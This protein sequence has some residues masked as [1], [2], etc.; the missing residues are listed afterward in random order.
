MFFANLS[1]L[2]FFGL[3]ALA[4]GATL[5]LYLLTRTRHR[6]VVS[7]LKFWH[8]AG[9]VP[10]QARRKRIDQPW[11]LLMQLLAIALLLLAMA[12]PRLG[13]P[14]ASGRDHVLLMDTSAWMGARTANGTL[15]GEAVRQALGWVRNLPAQDRVMVVRAAAL[16]TPATAFES[17]RGKVEAAIRA[18]RPGADA[19]DIEQAFSLATQAQRLDARQ[20]GEIAYAGASRVS[21][22]DPE[23]IAAPA[24]L[25]VLPVETPVENIGFTRLWLRR[26]E[27]R[28]DLWQ[29][30]VSARNYGRQARTAPMTLALGGAVIASRAMDLPAGGEATA[31]VEVRTRAAGWIEA[32]LDA[33]D[34]LESDN[35]ARLEIP[36]QPALRVAVYSP[37]PD[38]LRALLAS[39]KR[40]EP[41]FLGFSQY[42]PEPA[43]TD[44]IVL[45]RFAPPQPP[46]KPS[47]WIQPPADAS[48]IPA[49]AGQGTLELAHWNASHPLGAG[50]RARDFKLDQALLLTPGKG[51][52]AVAEAAGGA[53][54]AARTAAPRAVVLGFHPMLSPMRYEVTAPLLMANIYHW[55]APEVFMR[56]EVLTGSPGSISVEMDETPDPQ[57]VRVLDEQGAAL[58]F[59]VDG[60]TVRFF[61]P[62]PGTVRVGAGSLE[63]V[64][65]LSLPS[66]G[67][68]VWQAPAGAGRGPGSPQPS[69]PMPKEIWQWLAVAGAALLALE[70]WIYG[71]KRTLDSLHLKAGAALKIAAIAAALISVFEPAMGVRERKMSVTVLVDTSASVPGEDLATASAMARRIQ[72]ESGRNLVRVLPF[73]RGV[74]SL[75]IAESAGGLNLQRTAGE[76]GRATNLEAAIRESVTTLPAG[77]VPKL[78]LISDGRETLGSAARAAHQARQ[79]G[80]PVDT[81]SLAGRAEPRLKLQALRAPA[82]AFTGEKAPVELLVESP[83]AADGELEILAEGKTLGR[84]PVKL[85]PGLNQLRITASIATAGAIDLSGILRAGA[86][87][88][89]RFEQ[90]VSLRRPRVLYASMDARGQ[91]METQLLQTLGSA[92]FEVRTDADVRTAR[93]DD[94]QI[95]VLNNYDME[96]LSAD[97]KTELERYVQRGGGLLVIGGERNIYVEKKD[98]TL[99]A[100]DR[101]LPATVAPPRSPEGTSVVLIVDKSSS[102]EGRKMELARIAAI[103]VVDNLRPIDHVGVLIFDNSHQWAVPLRRAEDKMLIKRLIAGI[104]PDGGTQIAPALAEAFNRMSRAAGVYKHIVLLT[105]GISEEGNS[106]EIAAAA[107]QAKVT[108]S[109]VGLGQDVN[110]AYLE[111]V[112]SIAKGK[113]YVLTDPSGLEQILLK[114]VME[115]T[116]STTVEKPIQARVKMQAEILQSVGIE[117]APALKGYVRFEAKPRADT[118]LAVDGEDGKQD[119]LLSRWQYGLGRTAVFASDAK[120]RWAESWIGWAGYDKFWTNVLRDLLPHAQS[121]EATLTHDPANGQL[122]AEYRLAGHVAEP[123][124]PPSLYVIGPDGFR[125]AIEAKKAGDGFYRAV[126]PIG[127]R[128]GLFRVRP[129]EESRAFPEIGIYLPEP[130]LS[131]YGSNP[132]LLRQIAGYTGGLFNPAPEAVFNAGGRWVP[133]SLRLWPGLLA[134]ALLLNLGELAW[135]KLRKT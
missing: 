106:M 61:A 128:Q 83:E 88:E 56:R 63:H 31:T 131:T 38:L 8:D 78:V 59:T 68:S 20:P 65:S 119:P 91:A 35:A 134:L 40:V 104:T 95:V 22:R 29:V 75:D 66:L 92:Q 49:R 107:L 60:R 102:M 115:H 52:I 9:R 124:R 12:Q 36:A 34:A 112:A 71:R 114:D 121:G 15:E 46:R 72:S 120:A 23:T 118:I 113:S 30:Y 86:L 127:A 1:L 135:R 57:A 122:I 5:A 55:I 94:Y 67:E 109:T 17:D 126:A 14:D 28:P 85:E 58:P 64:F 79:L 37:Q 24:N 21:V 81:Y 117:Q 111:K 33:R 110:K 100:L 13:K 41:R 2:E 93:L 96:S 76:G 3:F 116:G 43:D 48:P 50:L 129:L 62:E 105:D 73:A 70:W 90:A 97:R 89:L 74:R 11:S 103:G 47:I 130:E 53:L 133:S 108:I 10:E 99:D 132:Q 51:D 123:A 39:D 16:A 101:A 42:A 44:L 27:G 125:K 6:F 69:A 87:G 77:L 82:V 84:R 32:R 98:K 18:S 19:L 26:S 4:G 45:D 25:R 7:S 54:I 80:I